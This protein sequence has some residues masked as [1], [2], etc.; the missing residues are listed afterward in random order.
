MGLSGVNFE[1]G[2][3]VIVKQGTKEPDSEE[4]EIGGW[5]GHIVEIDT[6]SDN[7][8]ILITIELDSLTLKIIPSHYIEQLER[9]GYD[10]QNMILYD[11]D[12]EKTNPRDKKENLK[13]VQDKLSDKYH[14]ASF[15]D[16]GKRITKVLNDVNPDDEMKCLQKWVGYLD[17][18]L[19]FPIHAIVSDSED[20]WLIKSG[21]KVLVKSLPHIVDMYGI[22]ASIRL[23]GEKFEFPLCDLEVIDKKKVDFQLIED[24]RTWFAN[25]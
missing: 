23:N 14:W 20:N 4:F 10:W 12:L 9:D 25:R 17:K 24:Y 11:S 18:E 15:G 16:K 21:D 19:T 5:Q 2:D 3:C 6:K 8:N 1:L 22:I 7:D 13:N